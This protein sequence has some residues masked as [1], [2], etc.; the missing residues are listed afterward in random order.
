MGNCTYRYNNEIKK[1]GVG[2]SDRERERGEK[3]GRETERERDYH[4]SNQ[5]GKKDKGFVSSNGIRGR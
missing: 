3:G 4:G 1:G 2:E 5:V